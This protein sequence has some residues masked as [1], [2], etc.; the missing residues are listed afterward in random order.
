MEAVKR[1][2]SERAMPGAPMQ[3]WYC[4]VSFSWKTTLGGGA[5]T[6]GGLARAGRA[7]GAAFLAAIRAQSS[8]RRSWSTLPAAATT[9]LGPT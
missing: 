3:T 7:G 9:R 5:A 1:R 6:S 8:T 4:S 2:R